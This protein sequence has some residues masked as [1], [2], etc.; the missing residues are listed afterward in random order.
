MLVPPPT[1]DTR[2]G[3]DILLHTHDSDCSGGKGDG[4]GN[5][6]LGLADALSKTE[7]VLAVL[8]SYAAWAVGVLKGKVGDVVREGKSSKSGGENEE[9]EEEEEEA[10]SESDSEETPRVNAGQPPEN[11]EQKEGGNIRT[12]AIELTPSG[13]IGFTRRSTPPPATTTTTTPS[14]ILPF[15]KRKSKSKKSKKMTLTMY[16]RDLL[17]LDLNPLSGSDVK[18]LEGV[19]GE[20][21]FKSRC[22]FLLSL[23]SLWY[24]S[25]RTRYRDQRRATART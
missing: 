4:K 2:E 6:N 19:V 12:S 15:I 17:S 10:S 16:P 20:Y 3:L 9:E 7:G 1:L 11:Q 22:F 23:L 24:R 21:A 18:Y 13:G 8:D 14:P 25:Q 5:G